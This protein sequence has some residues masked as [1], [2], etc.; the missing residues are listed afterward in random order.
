[1]TLD[2]LELLLVQIVTE[3]CANSHISEATA[4]KRM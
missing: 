2:G 1:M 3:F 4:A